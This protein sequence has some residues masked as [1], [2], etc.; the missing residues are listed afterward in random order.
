MFKNESTTDRERKRER[1][2]EGGKERGRKRERERQRQRQ[3]DD[4]KIEHLG[5]LVVSP[6]RGGR[7]VATRPPELLAAIVFPFLRA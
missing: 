7:N 3:M 6:F 1:R 5:R 4:D 2:R